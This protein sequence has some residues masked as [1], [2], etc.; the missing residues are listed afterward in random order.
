MSSPEQRLAVFRK[1]PLRAQLAMITSSKANQTL[2]QNQDYISSLE[3]VHAE[4]LADASAE[5]KLIY[6]KSQE[7][8]EE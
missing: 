1:M 5:A 4:C 6:K 3:Q 8:L 7:L 2:N